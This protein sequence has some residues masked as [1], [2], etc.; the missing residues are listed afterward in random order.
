MRLSVCQVCPLCPVPWSDLYPCASPCGCQRVVWIPVHQAARNDKFKI[1]REGKSGLTNTVCVSCCFRC[2]CRAEIAFPYLCSRSSPLLLL[3]PSVLLSSVAVL[4]LFP[5]VSFPFPGR[6]SCSMTHQSFQEKVRTKNFLMLKKSTLVQ[7]KVK[8]HL[9]QQQGIIRRHIA[10]K[11][12]TDKRDLRKVR[13]P[14]V[15]VHALL[16]CCCC[17]ACPGRAG[18]FDRPLSHVM[19][20]FCFAL[21]TLLFPQRRRV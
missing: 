20:G 19:T 18:A 15:P 4:S 13:C 21:C 12:T 16:L 6:S 7:A 1:K 5:S 17:A 2:C 9:Q 14:C 3:L 8:R 11:R 10:G